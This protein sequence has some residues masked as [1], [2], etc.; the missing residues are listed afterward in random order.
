VGLL[1]LD[2]ILFKIDG[3]LSVSSSLRFI[4]C[5]LSIIDFDNFLDST[6]LDSTFLDSTFL[7]STFLD[8]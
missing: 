6:F 1:S 4:L 2:F 5:D 8:S 3:K 7:D